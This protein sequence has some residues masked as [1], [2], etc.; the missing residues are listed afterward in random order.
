MSR[1]DYLMGIDIATTG[2]KTIII[3]VKGE[4]VGEAFS[5]Y[6]VS[7]PRPG[8]VEQDPH[9]W[10]KATVG[11]IQGAIRQAKIALGDIRGIGL[12]GQMHGATFLDKDGEPLINPKLP[13]MIRYAKES[14][15]AI[16]V[17]TTT[18]GS[19]FNPEKNLQLID[20]G[21]DK[22]FISVIGVSEEP[23]RDFAGYTINYDEK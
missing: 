22:I 10:W 6:P 16:Q 11:S 5:E 7:T 18:N 1:Q 17:D 3:N 21:L 9:D 19:L 23:Y 2:T 20:A 14:G 15:C 12:S 4:V 8:W 13:D